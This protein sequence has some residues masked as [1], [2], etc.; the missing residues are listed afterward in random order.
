MEF[1]KKL[2]NKRSFEESSNILI[3]PDQ[4]EKKHFLLVVL[5]TERSS[6]TENQYK[7]LEQTLKDLIC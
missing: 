5:C 2:L 3:L 4:T 1:F 7:L 6:P